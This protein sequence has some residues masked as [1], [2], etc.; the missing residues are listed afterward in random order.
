MI[1]IFPFFDLFNKTL[2]TFK[3]TDTVD[4][5]KTGCFVLCGQ[6]P[7][8]KVMPDDIVYVNIQKEDLQQIVEDHLLGNKVVERLLYVDP[9]TKETI[10]NQKGSKFYQKQY[11]IALRNCG[12]INPEDIKEYIAVR[13]YEAL[14]TVLT[15]SE[16]FILSQ[17]EY[18]QNYK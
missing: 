1:F 7:I 4:V 2:D 10:K 11:R 18:E 9:H 13:G 16:T 17:D 14:A 5:I 15:P 12:L 8:I 3:L 6:G